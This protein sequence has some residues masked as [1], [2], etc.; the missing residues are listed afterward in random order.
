MNKKEIVAKLTEI[1]SIW[2]MSD[3]ELMA[4]YPSIKEKDLSVES[5]YPFLSGFIQAKTNCLIKRIKEG[6]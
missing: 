2:K 4:K 1:N 6:E 5:R 3:A